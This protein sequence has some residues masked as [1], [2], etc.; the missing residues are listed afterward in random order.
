MIELEKELSQKL[1]YQEIKTEEN[2]DSSTLKKSTKTTSSQKTNSEISQEQK[3]EENKIKY[4]KSREIEKI[5]ILNKIY[6]K[7]LN[8]KGFNQHIIAYKKKAQVYKNLLL[9]PTLTNISYLSN[10]PKNRSFAISQSVKMENDMIQPFKVYDINLNSKICYFKKVNICYYEQKIEKNAN[11][12]KYSSVFYLCIINNYYSINFKVKIV[13]NKFDLSIKI[14]KYKNNFSSYFLENL[15]IFKDFN[16][17]PLELLSSGN[18]YNKFKAGLEFKININFPNNT[19]YFKW[20]KY[21]LNKSFYKFYKE[22]YNVFKMLN[23]LYDRIKQIIFVIENDRIY[24]FPTLR[25]REY[26][27]FIEGQNKNIEMKNEDYSILIIE[28]G[29]KIEI[30]HIKEI[31]FYDSFIEFCSQ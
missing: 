27:M 25:N 1:N 30:E 6:N 24:Q 3:F 12:Y 20:L 23:N 16:I 5:Q 17:N 21:E 9:E 13:N 19:K 26:P 31:G 8:L 7:Y 18:T 14:I 28:Y 10:D 29:D 11:K 15:L 4:K 2:N 22:G